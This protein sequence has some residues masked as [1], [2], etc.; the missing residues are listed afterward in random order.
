[1]QLDDARAIA[2]RLERY[3]TSN[4]SNEIASNDDMF[5]GQNPD[6][7]GVYLRVG[8]DAISVIADAMVSGSV[9]AP[10]SVLDLPCGFGRVTRHLAEFLPDSEIFVADLQEDGVRFCCDR[11]GT[12]PLVARADFE[13]LDFGRKFDLIWSGSLLTHL[14]V[15]RF[16]EALH[17]FARSLN[18]D[19]IAIV[20]LHGRYS[21]YLQHHGWKYLSDKRFAIA[22]AGFDETGFGYVDYADRERY[23]ITLS[24]PSFT[25]DVAARIPG[26]RLAGYCERRWS[27][28]HDVLVL[29]KSTIHQ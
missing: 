22:E 19:G 26:I 7:L 4:I 1:M 16:T 9:C 23:G 24:S 25:T 14:D 2:D 21:P 20:T 15:D 13:D 12:T 8:S 10:S 17:F 29:R 5:D 28:H 6:A 11:F 18:P 3:E 27:D